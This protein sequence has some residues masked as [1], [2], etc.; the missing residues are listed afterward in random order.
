[1]NPDRPLDAGLPTA[2][3]H[4]CMRKPVA[5]SFAAHDPT[6]GAGMAAD[7]AVF[8][9]LG[10]QPVGVLT[11]VTAQDTQGVA[12]FDALAPDRV[13]SQATLLI[14]DM[15]PQV[16][17]T[18]ALCNESV[19]QAV[20]HAVTLCGSVPLVVDPVMAS[21]RGDAL[22]SAGLRQALIKVLLPM[23]AVVTPNVPEALAL[24]GRSNI[25]DAVAW[26]FDQG[27][28]AVLL[29]GTHDPSTGAV[30]VNTLYCPPEMSVSHECLRL[31]RTYHGSGCTL[32]SAL[33][34]FLA[35][36]Q[37]LPQATSLALRYTWETLAS[38]TL[39][40]HG[41]AIPDRLHGRCLSTG[42]FQADDEQ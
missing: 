29:T 3:P 26:L 40:G 15:P 33:A 35:T 8:A 22:G 34:G 7:L 18:G 23:A 9:A 12:W 38:A 2:D 1:M 4:T 5:L 27:V 13:V 16:I 20:A 6:G 25:A 42:Y 19:V 21:G 10:C 37:A 14:A 41:Q 11:G 32:A 39:P 17:K 31:P 28:G 30:V 36:G 24:S